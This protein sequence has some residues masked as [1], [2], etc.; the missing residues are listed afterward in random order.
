MSLSGH[1]M[2]NYE[3]IQELAEPH[4]EKLSENQKLKYEDKAIAAAIVIRERADHLTFNG[5]ELEEFLAHQI[6]MSTNSI[7]EIAESIVRCKDLDKFTFHIVSTSNNATSANQVQPSEIAIIKFSLKFGVFDEIN[8]LVKPEI[9]PDDR[10][11]KLGATNDFTENL[12]EILKFLLPLETI[13]RFF[14][15]DDTK[16]GNET[17]TDT[18]EII[19][20]IFQQSQDDEI[21]PKV[22]VHPISEL[23]TVL[24]TISLQQKWQNPPSELFDSAHSTP[25]CDTHR[26]QNNSYTCC[27]SKARRMCYRIVKYC[28]DVSR[29]EVK[30]ESHHPHARN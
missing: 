18:A 20:R 21:S 11:V 24:R 23:F 5:L 14:A 30:P 28:C 4:W 19:S 10:Q 27:L 29:H 12:N 17:I 22:Q 7:D 8:I 13:P 25:G 16:F 3:K 9:T 26:E 1:E 15:D 2:K 6:E